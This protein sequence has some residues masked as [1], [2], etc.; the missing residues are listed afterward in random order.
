MLKIDKKAYIQGL[1]E[2]E[3]ISSYYPILFPMKA[4]SSLLVDQAA[5]FVQAGMT[6]YQWLVR[7]LI[8]LGY[9]IQPDIA[10]VIG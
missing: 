8:Y 10:F 9:R 6:V 3:V 5:D 2:S 4:S 1:L 7:K